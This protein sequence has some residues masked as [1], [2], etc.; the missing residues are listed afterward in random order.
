M[1]ENRDLK[2]DLQQ[3]D[4]ILKEQ[5]IS[6]RDAMK[7]MGLGGAALMAGTTSA[8]AATVANASSAKGKILIIGGGLAGVATAARLANNLSNPDIT[9]IEPNAES[10]SYQPGN[11][12][13][14]AGLWDRDDITYQTQ[15]LVNRTLDVLKPTYQN[16]K[17]AIA[18]FLFRNTR[19]ALI[20][21]SKIEEMKDLKREIENYVDKMTAEQPTTASQIILDNAEK[22]IESTLSIG[23]AALR[24]AI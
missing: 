9:I 20:T 4:A 3:L 5:G 11:T 10:V 1:I 23:L 13:I 16:L 21:L 8:I 18:S 17:D 22:I 24:R 6:R 2:K 19:E 12:L 7:M 14:G 15:D